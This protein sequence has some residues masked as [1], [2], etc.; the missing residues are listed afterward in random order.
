MKKYV[1]TITYTPENLDYKIS[2]GGVGFKE[3]NTLEYYQKMLGYLKDV[4]DSFEK[5]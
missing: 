1:M 3:E 2:F 4:V 5:G